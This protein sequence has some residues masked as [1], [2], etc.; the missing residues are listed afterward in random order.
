MIQIYEGSQVPFTKEEEKDFRR[1]LKDRPEL[2]KLYRDFKT[3][4]MQSLRSRL[5]RDPYL[6]ESLDKAFEIAMAS[7]I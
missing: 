2:K 4:E 7:G 6:D 5:G 1:L 3:P